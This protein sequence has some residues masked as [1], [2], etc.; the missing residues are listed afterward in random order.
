MNEE[1]Q[2][3]AYE[4]ERRAILV[5]RRDDLQKELADCNALLRKLPIGNRHERR[6]N[7][8]VLKMV[9]RKVAKAVEVAQ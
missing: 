3:R 6:R 1:E 8:S 2:K 5:Q 4:I 7:Q 9:T